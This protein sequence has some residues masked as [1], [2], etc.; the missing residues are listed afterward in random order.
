MSELVKEKPGYKTSEFWLTIAVA[1]IG[2]LIASGAL[3]EEH[4]VMKA[5][6]M[7]LATL[8]ALGYTASRANIK[9]SASLERAT[10]GKLAATPEPEAAEA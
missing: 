1:A 7:A 10:L 4:F 2:F 3:G 5:A 8:K 9:R 6:A